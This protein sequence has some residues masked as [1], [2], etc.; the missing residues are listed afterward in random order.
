M[1][2]NARKILL[3]KPG[4]SDHS[5][6]VCINERITLRWILVKQSVEGGNHETENNYQR[7]ALVNAVKN[8]SV[9]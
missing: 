4:R 5:K 9:P 3:G 2:R 7:L 6:D 1:I 8:L